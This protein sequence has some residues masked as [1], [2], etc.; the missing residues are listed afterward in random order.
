LSTITRDRGDQAAGDDLSTPLIIVS[1]DTHIGPRLRED[2][3]AYCP[4]KYLEQYDDFCTY[5]EGTDS[6]RTSQEANLRTL[7]RTDG[8]YDPHA[9]LRDLDRDGTAAEVIFHGSQNGQPIPFVVSDPSIGIATMG[10]SYDVD[11]ELA[12]VGRHMYNQWLADFCSVEPERHIGLAHLPLWD[13]EASVKEMEWARSVGLKG[14]NFPAEAGPDMANKSRWA[15]THY[16]HDPIWEPFWAA[17]ESL[18]MPLA[19]HG[20][21]G[22]PTKLPGGNPIWV[23]EGLQLSRRPVAR[24]IFSGVFARHPG[25]KLVPT[26][27]PGDW[28]SVFLKDMDSVY[29]TVGKNTDPLPEIP[30]YYARKNVFMGASFQARFEAEDAISNDYW[31]NVLWGTDYPHV[32]GT[33]RYKEEGETQVPYSILSLRFTYHDLPG[34]CVR[35]MVGENALRVYDLDRDALAKV[36]D[37]INAPTLG[38]ALQ[39]ID[40]VPTDGGMW[41]FRQVGAFW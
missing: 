13:M 41:A 23:L 12:A 7:L 8:H 40:E 29:M 36:A 30:S 38:D 20:G 16:Y 4:Q 9:R 5:V 3:R 28:W 34:E 6:L 25:L 10:R 18:D 14:I 2:L 39:P 19:T 31:R 22:N 35:G 17:A 37:R 24:M 21:A 27:Q 1:C 11:Y 26:E 33:W 15:G 32:E